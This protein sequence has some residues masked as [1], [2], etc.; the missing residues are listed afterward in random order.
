MGPWSLN[1]WPLTH[2]SRDYRLRCFGLPNNNPWAETP[3]DDVHDEHDKE[4]HEDQAE[5]SGPAVTPIA[6]V[7]WFSRKWTAP[8]RAIVK[9]E[10]LMAMV[11]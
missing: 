6:G 9:G 8:G 10:R 1:R 11:L 3:R 7:C 2:F 5:N 4:D